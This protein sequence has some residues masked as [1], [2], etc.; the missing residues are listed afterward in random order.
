MRCWCCPSRRCS[1]DDRCAAADRGCRRPRWRGAA[2]AARASGE[3][4]PRGDRG[5]GPRDGAHGADRRRCRGDRLRPSL[6]RRRSGSSSRA[7]TGTR[8]RP[9]RPAVGGSCGAGARHHQ[10]AGVP[11]CAAAGA[12]LAGDHARG[13][14]RAD[15]ATAG[16]GR[17]LCPGRQRTAALGAH[18][19]RRPGRARRRASPRAL[20]ARARRSCPPGHPRHGPPLRSG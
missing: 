20:H 8:C 2:R 1:H 9:R 14:L 11:C 18:H 12:A 13:A 19:V 6:R 7:T 16:L 4:G 5:A 3:R 17:A 10:C 15:H